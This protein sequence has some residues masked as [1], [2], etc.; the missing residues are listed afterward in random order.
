MKTILV[1]YWVPTI[2]MLEKM[3]IPHQ[4]KYDY[5]DEKRNSIIDKA[6]ENGYQVM[7]HSYGNEKLVMWIDRNCFKQR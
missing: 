3:G 4:A 1:V 2:T 7:L 5:T 6:L